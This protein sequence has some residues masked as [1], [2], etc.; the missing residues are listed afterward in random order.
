M[1]AWSY[2]PTEIVNTYDRFRRES[3]ETRQPPSRVLL[4]SIPTTRAFQAALRSVGDQGDN[5]VA[6]GEMQ[7]P[8]ISTND[9]SSSAALLGIS[10]AV[11]STT[12]SVRPV[13][14]WNEGMIWEGPFLDDMRREPPS[15]RRSASSS[16]LTTSFF[17][18][19]WEL[20]VLP[21]TIV[22]DGAMGSPLVES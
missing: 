9:S 1:S 3:D 21:W 4:G 8:W 10:D 14:Q 13:V 22:Q 7:A 5:T 18:V 20:D 2:W 17:R 16:R 15:Q 19:V 12:W 11:L 6:G